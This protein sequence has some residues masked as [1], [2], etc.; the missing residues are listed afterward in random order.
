GL[1]DPAHR[2]GK[3]R[4]RA[5]GHEDLAAL[6]DHRHMQPGLG[7]EVGE[8]EPGSQN[9]ARR[10]EDAVSRVSRPRPVTMAEVED[11]VRG[12]VSAAMTK[13]SVMERAHEMERIA[14]AVTPA[15]RGANHAVAEPDRR[16]HTLHLAAIEEADLVFARPD[17]HPDLA[18][19]A[20]TR[21]Q[22]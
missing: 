2:D 4:A 20:T 9:D 11:L 22:R 16:Q 7:S 19:V 3:H 12:K 6:G 8:A 5:L 18:D 1:P 14:I 15:E 17:L 10:L 21:S 13:D